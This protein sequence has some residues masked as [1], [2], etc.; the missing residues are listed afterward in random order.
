MFSLGWLLFFLLVLTLQQV[1]KIS[2][3]HILQ[4][5]TRDKQW[6]PQSPFLVEAQQGC[7]SE[8]FRAL[9]LSAQAET[10]L[11]APTLSHKVPHL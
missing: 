4:S 6:L 1:S 3:T 2:I 5:T 9:R 11:S 10:R 8:A 7:K